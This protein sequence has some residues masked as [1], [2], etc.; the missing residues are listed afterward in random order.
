LG[1]STIIKILKAILAAVTPLDIPTI[2]SI[3]GIKTT[4]HVVGSLSSVLSVTVDGLVYILH[5][6]FREFLEDE[7]IAGAFHVDVVDGHIMM[8]K[9]CLA[10]MKK[11]LKFNICQL[12]SSFYLN[13]DVPDLKERISSYISKELQYGCLYWSDH[14][15]NSGNSVR[16]E[17][18]NVAVGKIL[19]DVYP[20]Y[21]IEVMSALERV[22][23]A[24]ASLQNLKKGP[25]VSL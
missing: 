17:Q 11:Q 4:K 23:R 7:A 18:V 24:L 9:G 8:A 19:D 6:T 10:I 1:S 16:N 12:E 5:P 22:P 14:V 2:N 15:V 3:L 20:F 13:K 25:L 21:L